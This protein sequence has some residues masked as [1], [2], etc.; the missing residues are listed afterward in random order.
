MDEGRECR[1]PRARALASLGLTW[2]GRGKAKGASTRHAREWS[3][4]F[5]TLA[6]QG[7]DFLL[8]FYFMS[9]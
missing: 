6:L 9:A 1:E 2:P 8:S 3:A 5:R 4:K 7:R